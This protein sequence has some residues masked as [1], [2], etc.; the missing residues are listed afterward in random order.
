MYDFDDEGIVSYTSQG[1]RDEERFSGQT[2][3]KS[4][5]KMSDSKVI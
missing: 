1:K 5:K 3:K 4:F 2:R